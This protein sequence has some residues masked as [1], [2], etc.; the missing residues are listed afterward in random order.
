MP[1]RAPADAPT[2]DGADQLADFDSLRHD[3]SADEDD[4][5]AD[6]NEASNG[7]QDKNARAA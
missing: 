3:A 6:E 7:G 2:V 1:P 5:S 4:A